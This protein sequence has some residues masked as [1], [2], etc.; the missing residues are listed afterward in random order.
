MGSQRSPTETDTMSLDV[1]TASIGLTQK[2]TFWSNYV[3]ALKGNEDLRAPEEAIT[4]VWYPSIVETIPPEFPSLKH[5]FS[6]L[7]NQILTRPARS[8]P[9]TPVLPDAHDRIFT[10]GYQYVPI[11]ASI[12][13]SNRA[14]TARCS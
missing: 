13:G 11:S 12:Y 10:G 2:A 5:E 3:S 7:E 4:R 9:L 8:G 14:R 1:Y 6:K